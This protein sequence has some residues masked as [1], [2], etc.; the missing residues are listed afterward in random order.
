MPSFLAWNLTAGVE[1][2]RCKA[3][4]GGVRGADFYT[5]AAGAG[6]E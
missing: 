6:V 2:A 5:G 3:A 4:A 1:R